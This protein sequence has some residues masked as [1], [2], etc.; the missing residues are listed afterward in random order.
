M[1]EAQRQ[2]GKVKLARKAVEKTSKATTKGSKRHTKEARKVRQYPHL[3]FIINV[4]ART[5][6]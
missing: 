1:S 3:Y 5:T 2:W 4:N 6:K